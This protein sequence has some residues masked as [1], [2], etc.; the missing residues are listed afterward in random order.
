MG[1]VAFIVAR[2]TFI[3]MCG[4]RGESRYVNV[5][6]SCA[7]EARNRRYAHREKRGV[8]SNNTAINGS[9]TDD[10]NDKRK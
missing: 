10:I 8:E 2:K 6:C 4:S 3:R 7:N 9:D 5:L 1:V